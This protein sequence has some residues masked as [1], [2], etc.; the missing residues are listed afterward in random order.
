MTRCLGDETGESRKDEA[1]VESRPSDPA[2]LDVR[3]A[4]PSVPSDGFD[5]IYLFENGREVGVLN[6]PQNDP[7]VKR[8]ADEWVKPSLSRPV[9]REGTDLSGPVQHWGVTV[10]ING[11][12]ALTIESNCL[13]GAPNIDEYRDTVENCAQHLLSFIGLGLTKKRP[14]AFR[15]RRANDDGLT[16]SDDKWRL[17]LDE[18]EA[19]REA[20]ALCIDYQGLYV[21]DGTGSPAPA[22]TREEIARAK[23]N[24]IEAAAKWIEQRRD[25]Y[26]EEHGNY[27]YSTGQMEFPGNGVEY[28]GELDE[29]V[30]GLRALLPGQPAVKS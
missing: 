7:N 21:R 29:I 9:D 25:S 3:E 26:V 20:D 19:A 23:D 24:G 2:P 15:V 27:D 13:S 14:V 5:C 4:R 28:V 12:N 17:F 8:R 10:T 30:E 16:L 1:G 22:P 6:G 11:T 18:S